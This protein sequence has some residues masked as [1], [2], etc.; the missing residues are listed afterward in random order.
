VETCF[1]VTPETFSVDTADRVRIA[2]RR[3]GSVPARR[4]VVICHGFNVNQ[5]TPKLVAMALSLAR[6]D[7]AVYTFDFRGHGESG[8]LS[9]LGAREIE[10]LAAVMDLVRARAHRQVVVVGA[11]MG[12][13]VALRH[14]ALRG[15]EDAVVAISAP[16]E[17]IE[18]R[19]VRA[20]LLGVLIST[21]PGRRLLKAA[22][23][24]MAV[25]LGDPEPPSRIAGSIAPTPLGLIHGER[26]RYVPVDA[27]LA[28][29]EKLGEPKRMVVLDR[30]GHAEA[31]FTPPFSSLVA[32]LID[33]LLAL[34]PGSSIRAGTPS[35]DAAAE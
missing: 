9:T 15:G 22:G 21:R 3:Y 27:A 4:A 13:F 2:G 23:T 34:R 5:L 30:F 24:R 10:D 16:T 32:D 26:D 8:G 12:G 1:F 7:T 18:P 20:K 33:E 28:L 19:L 35:E 6:P 17:W 25:E 14:A 31:G 29:Y 11:S